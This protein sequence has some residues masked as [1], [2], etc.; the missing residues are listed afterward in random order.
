MGNVHDVEPL[1]RVGAF[2]LIVAGK[3]SPSTHRLT[4][5]SG[6]GYSATWYALQC[7][8]GSLW[9][10]MRTRHIGPRRVRSR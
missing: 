6:V 2:V 5:A 8:L 4:T 9:I 1:S 7:I 10:R 3:P